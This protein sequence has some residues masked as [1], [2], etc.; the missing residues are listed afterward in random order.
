M[1]SPQKFINQTIILAA[2]IGPFSFTHGVQAA[3]TT[4]A[5]FTEIA[6]ILMYH[7]IETAPATTSLP[8]LYLAPSIFERQLQAL[9]AQK[10][11]TVFVSEVAASLR[12]HQPLSAKSVALSFD[13]GYE[14][15]Y[16]QAW[17]LLEKYQ[18]KST[19]YIIINALDKPG[20]L[21]KEQVKNLAG[22]GLVEIGSHT[23]NHPD[24]RQLKPKDARFEI[25][26][27]RGVL[28]KLT[29]QEILTFAY[30]YGYYQPDF[31]SLASSTGYLSAVSVKPGAQQSTSN[32][33]AMKRLRPNDRAGRVFLNWLA[34]W[35]KQ[36]NPGNKKSV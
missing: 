20:Y 28:Q 9:A 14:D 18:I 15:F 1:F 2:L 10:Y 17:P 5:V 22:S 31:F 26:A 16:T 36:V 21:T 13:D 33:W 3:T 7:Y 24:L 30:P 23:F 4:P 25:S 34:R 12:R 8:G 27:S 29:G 19:I 32:L 6:P 35:F 11:Q